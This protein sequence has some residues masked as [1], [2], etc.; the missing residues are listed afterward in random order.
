VQPGNVNPSTD[1][2]YYQEEASYTPGL[3]KAGV[4][5]SKQSA[6]TSPEKFPVLG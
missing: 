1:Y 2:S 6:Q 3:K 5:T 4:N